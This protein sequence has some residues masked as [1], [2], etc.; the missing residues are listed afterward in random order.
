[1]DTA[2]GNVEQAWWRQGASGLHY[3]ADLVPT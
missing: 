3:P 1:M 2:A